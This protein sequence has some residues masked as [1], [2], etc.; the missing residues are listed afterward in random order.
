[1]GITFKNIHVFVLF[2][3]LTT[4]GQQNMPTPAKKNSVF[5]EIGGQSMYASISYDRLLSSGNRMNTSATCGIALLPF[6][7]YFLLNIPLGYS[8]LLGQK[9]HHFE[10][11]PGINFLSET[12]A[13]Q[14]YTLLYLT[15]KVAYRFQRPT[16]GLFL[17]FS[18][19]P[20]MFGIQTYPRAK[21]RGLYNN[22]VIDA[23]D[24]DGLNWWF[25][26]AVGWTIK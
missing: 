13:K 7:G 25:G 10:F 6:K 12:Q 15:P 8:F 4:F 26:L 19:V 14:T 21:A 11:G 3:S 20:A 17:R 24:D 2:I 9:N 1:M 18:F 16:G 23:P 5:L 22:S